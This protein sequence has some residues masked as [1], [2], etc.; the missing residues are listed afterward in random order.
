MSFCPPSVRGRWPFRFA[1]LFATLLVSPVWADDV[2]PV[3][4][5][6]AGSL[7]AAFKELLLAFDAPAGTILPPVF[8]PSGV[9]RQHIEE[10][11]AADLFASADMAQPRRL[12]TAGKGLPVVMFARNRLC[13]VARQRLGLTSDNMLDRLL[14]PNLRLATSTP[15]ADPAGDYAWA[16]FAKADKLHPGAEATLQGKALKLVGAAD[17]KPLVPGH[18]AVA[19]IFLAD[20]ADTMM[21]YCSGSSALIKE[22][23]GLV[24][25]SMPPALSVGPAYGMIVLTENP[26][27]AR[28][29]LFIMSEQGQR[30]LAHQGFDPVALATD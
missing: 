2:Q 10:G 20:R 7:G 29:A 24:S 11:Q 25:V 3:R 8:G 30:I 17:S 28:F 18:S 27:A 14:D 22:V 13:V 5:M 23:P 15:G 19:G 26:A 1:L 9:L 12:A 4:I 21:G 6:A 16:V